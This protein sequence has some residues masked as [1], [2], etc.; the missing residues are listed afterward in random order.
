M[1]TVGEFVTK[2][3]QFIDSD[4]VFVWG[5]DGIEI[6]PITMDALSNTIFST[7][8]NKD[9]Y[10][11]RLSFGRGKLGADAAGLINYI[12]GDQKTAMQ[13]MMQTADGKT[14]RAYPISS[15]PENIPCLVI[16]RKTCAIGVYL[17]DTCV[18]QM[19]DDA[20]NGRIAPINTKDWTEWFFPY[21]V[22]YGEMF[23]PEDPLPDSDIRSYQKW[24]NEG[25]R[26]RLDITGIYDDATE[27]VSVKV[28]QMML[29]QYYGTTIKIDGVLTEDTWNDICDICLWDNHNGYQ[30]I[31]KIVSMYVKTKGYKSL[32]MYQATQ[33]GLEVTGN[34]TPATLYRMFCK[35]S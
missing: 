15:L 18:A 25:Y 29:N 35:T 30:A 3:R 32:G 26:G 21:F 16:N 14:P 17:G 6:T 20:I 1:M 24:I 23:S 34:I 33:R 22:D 8:H 27:F 10:A 11:S 31:T 28:L 19:V 2:C 12:S 7:S 5:A 4:P 13:Y 9:Y